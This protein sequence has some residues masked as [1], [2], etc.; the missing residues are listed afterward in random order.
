MWRG[1][2]FMTLLMY[3]RA[4]KYFRD[5]AKTSIYGTVL[6]KFHSLCP[7]SKWVPFF[8]NY[9]FNSLICDHLFQDS[10]DQVEFSRIHK[11]IDAFAVQLVERFTSRQQ[12][13][14]ECLHWNV[15][16]F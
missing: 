1:D 11:S 15:Y 7:S 4:S 14:I 12:T 5:F 9:Y 10:I 16:Q 3:L 8:F 13:S 6:N 2:E